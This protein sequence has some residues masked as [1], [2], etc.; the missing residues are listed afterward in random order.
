VL[1]KFEGRVTGAT[2]YLHLDVPPGETA[3]M[4][5][6]ALGAYL[7]DYREAVAAYRDW[8]RTWYAPIASHP[9]WFREVCT[10]IG[11]TPT[12]SMFLTE[13]GGMDLSPHID[14]MA[15]YFGPIDYQ[16]VYG[17]F[18]SQNNGGQGDYS[19]Y[20]LLGGEDAWRGALQGLEED[21]GVRTGLYLDPLLMDEKAEA[22]EAASA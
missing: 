12:L 5:E 13:D 7:G 1:E 4:P 20:E 10:L 18:A 2:R 19:H 21:A 15:E 8:M 17:W 3:A 9:E 6:V 11:I 14:R 22:A 16:H